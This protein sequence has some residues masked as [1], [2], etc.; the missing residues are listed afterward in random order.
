MES[1]ARA[2]KYMCVHVDGCVRVC[3]CVCYCVCV[4]HVSGVCRWVGGCLFVMTTFSLPEIKVAQGSGDTLS[5]LK[6]LTT[7]SDGLHMLKWKHKSSFF[8]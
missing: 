5:L 1:R 7:W 4:L 6:D 2:L 3:T 8:C